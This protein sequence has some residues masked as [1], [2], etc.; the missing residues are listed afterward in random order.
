[1]S[2][3]LSNFQALEYNLLPM[4]VCFQLA[5]AVVDKGKMQ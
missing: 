1:M 2:I 3:G 5:K 4:Y